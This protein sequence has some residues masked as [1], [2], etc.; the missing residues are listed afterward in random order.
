MYALRVRS[1]LS[2][3]LHLSLELRKH[4][5]LNAFM[6]HRIDVRRGGVAAVGRFR[7]E[8]AG[9]RKAERERALAVGVKPEHHH[10]IGERSENLAGVFHAS[11]SEGNTG[12]GRFQIEV[13]IV[14]RRLFD[15]V[16]IQYQAAERKV[17]H[18]MRADDEVLADYLRGFLLLAREDQVADF[19]EAAQ[20]SR[21]VVVVRTSAPEGLVVQL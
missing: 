4:L 13:A 16:E 6:I 9:M 5:S 8:R 17:F 10:V 11:G 15:A 20:R 1:D 14:I 3:G 18:A 19:L 12:H 7:R 21:A 2:I